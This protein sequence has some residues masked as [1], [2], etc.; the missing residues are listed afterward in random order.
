MATQSNRSE[1]QA[2][3]NQ[4]DKPVEIAIERIEVDHALPEGVVEGLVRQRLKDSYDDAY[5]TGKNP[6][7]GNLQFTYGR[8]LDCKQITRST[9][10][11]SYEGIELHFVCYNHT[12]VP[13]WDKGWK[14]PQLDA[15]FP[16]EGANMVVLAAV[17]KAEAQVIDLVATNPADSTSVTNPPSNPTNVNRKG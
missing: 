1:A 5:L 14:L 17:L 6:V 4:A 8:C 15:F 16:A 11:W 3:G 10:T 12:K 2:S 9:A 13:T 7:T